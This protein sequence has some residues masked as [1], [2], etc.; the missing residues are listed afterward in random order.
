MCTLTHSGI[1]IDGSTVGIAYVGTMCSDRL[2]VGLTQDN[3]RSIDGVGA[4]AA[5]E[6]GH[7]FNMRHD[8]GNYE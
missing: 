8:D 7:V 4:T 2:S 5:H 1:D 6:M 3:G